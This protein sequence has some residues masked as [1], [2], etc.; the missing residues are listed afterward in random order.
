MLDKIDKLAA[1]AQIGRM[2]P[3]RPREERFISA[4]DAASKL[5][6]SVNTVKRRVE[7][8]ILRGY[9]DPINNYYSVAEASVEDLLELRQALKRS[10]ALPGAGRPRKDWARRRTRSGR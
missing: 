6:V 5:D 10:A 2:T 7:A 4:A 9:Q 1:P 3:T 8:G